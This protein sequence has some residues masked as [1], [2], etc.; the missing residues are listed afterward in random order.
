VSPFYFA[1]GNDLFLIS[2]EMD[3]ENANKT[4]EEKTRI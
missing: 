2:G 4:E 3:G 1:T